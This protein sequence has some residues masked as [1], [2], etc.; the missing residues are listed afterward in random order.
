MR[1]ALLGDIHAN[2]HALKV[3][4]DSA[5]KDSVD[6]LLITGDLIGYYFDPS[7]VL[8]LLKPWNK[9]V[10]RG[11]HE[12]MLCRS[13]GDPAYLNKVSSRYG[14]GIKEAIKQLSAEDLDLLCNLPHPL[15]FVLGGRK[16][17]LCHGSPNELSHYIYPDTDLHESEL[18]RM[19]DFD[20]V[21]SGHT[22][23]PMLRCVNKNTLFVNPGSV[24]QPRNHK[25]G[26]YWALYD[27]VAGEVSFRCDNYDYSVLQAEAL[28]RHP[29]LPYLADVLGRT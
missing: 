18:M 25:P 26:A 9:Y 27:T 12:D 23:Y 22:H 11:N 7:L 13:R 10:V 16:I 6:I 5:R 24:G 20:L 4:L 8:E 2:A 29:E 21:V 15:S 17:L 3:V 28:C 14:S 1:L 19:S